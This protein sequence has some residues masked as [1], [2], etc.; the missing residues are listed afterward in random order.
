MVAHR[1]S[2][3]NIGLYLLATVAARDLGWIGTIEMVERLEATLATVG[4]LEQYRGHLY[5][6]YDTRDLHPLEPRTCPRSTAA[7]SPAI[8]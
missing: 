2:P 3:T 4:G 1:T 6:W 7:T 5:N 8:C